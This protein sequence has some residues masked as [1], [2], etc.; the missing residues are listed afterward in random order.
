MLR[1]FV[2]RTLLETLFVIPGI[3]SLFMVLFSKDGKSLRDRLANTII[4]QDTSYLG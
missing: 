2:G 4:V 1:E 3:I